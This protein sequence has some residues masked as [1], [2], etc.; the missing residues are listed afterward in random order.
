MSD[1][2]HSER[3]HFEKAMITLESERSTLYVSVEGRCLVKVE[4]ILEEYSAYLTYEPKRWA[5][6]C[7][8]IQRDGIMQALERVNHCLKGKDRRLDLHFFAVTWAHRI[9]LAVDTGILVEDARHRGHRDLIG[10]RRGGGDRQDLSA[11][12][13]RGG[14]PQLQVEEESS[15][16]ES[17]YYSVDGSDSGDSGGYKEESG[18]LSSRTRSRHNRL[19]AVVDE[20]PLP[21]W[22][23]GWMAG[24]GGHDYHAV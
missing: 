22:M 14:G 19:L 3:G 5:I 8:L 6:M 2:G 4:S 18:P 20:V 16:A 7:K 12:A 24:A 15:S 23:D 21:C 17:V 13:G 10:H 1:V 9:K 11:G